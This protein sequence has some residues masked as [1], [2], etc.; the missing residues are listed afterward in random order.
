MLPRSMFVSTWNSPDTQTA[1][2]AVGARQGEQPREAD[3]NRAA[4]RCRRWTAQWHREWTAQ[5]H[6]LR[7]GARRGTAQRD[8][9]RLGWDGEQPRYADGDT[10]CK[11]GQKRNHNWFIFSHLYT[12]TNADTIIQTLYVWLITVRKDRCRHNRRQC[13]DNVWLIDHCI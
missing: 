7:T 4:Q 5:S 6:R 2:G 10:D 12:R 11:Q 8:D 1:T 9:N 3:G 13:V